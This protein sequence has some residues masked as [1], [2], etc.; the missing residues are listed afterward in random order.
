MTTTP[1]VVSSKPV[2]TLTVT[3]DKPTVVTGEAAQLSATGAD[4]YAWTP[5]G[6]LSN[7][8]IANP[9]ATPAV[10]T[11]YTVAGTL[12]AG[13]TATATIDITVDAGS[14]SIKAPNVFSPNGDGINEVL[15]IEGIEKYPDNRVILY[16][17]NGMKVYEA[18]GYDNSSIAFNGRSSTSGSLLDAG[19]YFYKIEYTVNGAKKYKTGFIVLKYK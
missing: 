15:K 17:R 18:K 9:I 14:I 19:S 3:T 1:A 5:P 4:T 6:T 7:A 8:A 10:T 16:N 12:T 13:C 11:T 2:P